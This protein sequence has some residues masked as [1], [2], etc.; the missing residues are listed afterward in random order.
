MKVNP[1]KKDIF[2]AIEMDI[3]FTNLLFLETEIEK[4]NDSDVFKK[5]A[6]LI[7]TEQYT[8]SFF[9]LLK[10]SLPIFSPAI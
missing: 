4:S 8:N 3:Y 5:I 1:Y 7:M 9:I 10:G 6:N 2:H